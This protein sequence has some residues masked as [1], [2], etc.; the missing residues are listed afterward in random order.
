M[1]K[2]STGQSCQPASRSTQCSSDF[3]RQH[4][5]QLGT[6]KTPHLNRTT[7]ARQLDQTVVARLWLNPYP[8]TRKL[9]SLAAPGGLTLHD[10]TCAL[11]RNPLAIGRMPGIGQK[12]QPH[13]RDFQS[14]KG[15]H[16]SR[17]LQ[18]EKHT[19][20][21]R[22]RTQ[23]KVKPPQLGWRYRAIAPEPPM[24][25]RARLLCELVSGI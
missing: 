4:L 23:R 15:Q 7:L 18:P 13:Q 21:Q 16:Q 24:N 3:S 19:D 5:T 20:T 22:Q 1:D 10:K 9:C 2:T 8:L 25:G 12:G 17:P 11:Q 6:H 14:C